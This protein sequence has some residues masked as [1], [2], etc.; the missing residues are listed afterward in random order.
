MNEGLDQDVEDKEE[1]DPKK[2][3][4]IEKEKKELLAS[5]SGGDF[6]KQKTKVAHILNLYP[7]ARNSDITLTLKYWETFQPDIFNY[8]GILPKD[9]F[10]L[11]RLHYIVRARAK[12]QNEYCLFTAN[13]TVKGFRRK[14]EEAMS[15]EILADV[16]PRKL[17]QVYADETGKTQSYVIVTSV[18]VLT[19]RAVFTVS[20]AIS[21]W[22]NQSQWANREVHFAKLGKQDLETLKEYL[23]VIIQNR[24]YLSFKSIAVERSKTKRSIESVVEKLHENMLLRGA[25]HEIRT[26]RIGLP[27]KIEVTLDH[28]QSLD[29]ITL[30][31]IKRRV[32]FEYTAK[33]GG[34]VEISKIETISSRNSPLVQ[35]SDL[36]AG[37]INRRLNHNGERNY[38]D[39]MADLVITMLDLQFEESHIDGL[40]ISALFKI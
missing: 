22:K 14:H 10:R 12:I 16:I 6:S 17:V 30:D 8:N 31:E 23:S 35:L 27:Q 13:S 7:E 26:G 1:F 40:D 20:Q 11:D 29:A 28:E 39:E 21:N 34:G 3:A 32:N 15:E 37:A 24:E 2:L 38:K 5:L 36:A 25:D 18:W 33:H 19:G 4:K 9:L